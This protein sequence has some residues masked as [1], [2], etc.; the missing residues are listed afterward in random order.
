MYKEDGGI[1]PVGWSLGLNLDHIWSKGCISAWRTWPV[2][3]KAQPA[4]SDFLCVK[5]RN[6]DRN[7]LGSKLGCHDGE[8]ELPWCIHCRCLK[9]VL[10]VKHSTRR[11]LPSWEQDD[12]VLLWHLLETMMSKHYT[13]VWASWSEMFLLGYG[14]S[15]QHSQG[16]RDGTSLQAPPQHA[17]NYLSACLLGFAVFF[18]SFSICTNLLV[19]LRSNV[20]EKGRF[21][22]EKTSASSRVSAL[23]ILATLFAV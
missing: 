7:R 19:W 5:E 20:L 18:D 2:L 15:E 23:K 17:C 9:Y 22:Q 1:F 21:L 10:C 6:G 13:V 8:A 11:Q 3:F 12:C 14:D 16:D 4:H